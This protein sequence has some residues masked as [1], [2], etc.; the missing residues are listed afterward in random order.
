MNYMY[1][2]RGYKFVKYTPESVKMESV[3]LS[4]LGTQLFRILK[5][6]MVD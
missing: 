1:V 4:I 5:V 2:A 6:R 3:I